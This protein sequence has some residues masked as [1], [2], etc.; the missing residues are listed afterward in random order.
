MRRLTKLNATPKR[1]CASKSASGGQI[2]FNSRDSPLACHNPLPIF[3]DF[4][5]KG[6]HFAYREDHWKLILARGSGGW[7]S[8]KENEVPAGSPDVQLYDLTAD[9][10][11]QQNLWD[12]QPE[13]VQRLLARLKQDVVRG[14]STRGPKSENDV[15]GIVLWKSR[16]EPKERKGKSR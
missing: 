10:G 16:Q 11:E 5:F 8:L 2:F 12:K 6:G 4:S 3:T 7:T 13:T 15:D 1:F 14:R 9:P